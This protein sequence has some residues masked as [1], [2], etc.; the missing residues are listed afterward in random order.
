M[1]FNKKDK[2]NTLKNNSKYRTILISAAL[3]LSFDLGVLLPNVIVSSSLKRDAVKI[4]LAGRQRMLSQRMTKSLL[5]VK[6]FQS[7]EKGWSNYKEELAL[8]TKLFDETLS[9]FEVGK[10]VTGG[11]GKPVFLDPAAGAKGKQII[12]DAKVIWEPYKQKLLL[13]TNSK[14]ALPEALLQDAIAYASQNNLKLLDLMNQLTT[15]EQRNAD[16]KASILQIV[17][18]AGLF[19]ALINFFVLLSHSLRKLRDGDAAIEKANAEIYD[20]SKRLEAENIR[21]KAELD[22]TREVQKMILPKQEDLDKIPDLDIAGF[23]QPASD[24]GGDYYDVISHEGRVKIGIGDVTGSGLE[25]GMLMLMVQTAMRTL[26]TSNET[27]PKKFLSVLNQTIYHSAQRMNTDK[28]MS[29][30]LLDYQNG[31]IRIS[32]QHEEMLVVRRGG[33]IQRVDTADLGFT[34]GLEEDITKFIAYAD[35]HL[36]PGDAVVLY[37]DGL[38]EAENS[39][40]VNYG[41]KRLMQIIKENWQQ[42]PEE[43]KQAVIHDFREFIGKQVPLDDITLLILKRK[44]EGE[45]SN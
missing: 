25:S 4:N 20:L 3:F 37:T 21:I 27:D 23:M 15:E 28:N 33:L 11:D 22:W 36:Y 34:I 6:L 18:T 41:L 13:I 43:I 19:L 45:S 14:D 1:K 39:K 31:K 12:Q 9:G 29:L 10:M 35:V 5:Q 44:H 24:M 16:N 38:T 40:K 8:S 2:L 17:Q 26:L 32:G 30:C 42:S 7:T